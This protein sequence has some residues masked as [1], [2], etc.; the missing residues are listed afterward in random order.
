MY[1]YH[2][3]NIKDK[4]RLLC[5]K[6]WSTKLRAREN[7]ARRYQAFLIKEKREG[8]AKERLKERQRP[9]FK[10]GQLKKLT[11]DQQLKCHPY[12]K[13]KFR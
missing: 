4:S 13:E 7:T 1:G 3:P 6:Q 9:A 8:Y 2:Y 11:S 10:I 12:D 5:R